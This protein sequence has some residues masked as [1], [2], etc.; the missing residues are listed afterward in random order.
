MHVT[1]YSVQCALYSV[2][3]SVYS[4]QCVMDIVL[5]TVDS[6]KCAVDD[7]HFLLDCE[8]MN[9]QSNIAR[10]ERTIFDCISHVSS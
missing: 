4:V 5:W 3:L 8:T 7:R 6:L 2:Q 1:V 10:R 9:I